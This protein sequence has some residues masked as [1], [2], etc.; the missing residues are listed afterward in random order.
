MKT[1]QETISLLAHQAFGSYM[2][3]S[4]APMQNCDTG[5]VSFIFEIGKYVVDEDLR[6]KYTQ[7]QEEY[8]AKLV[9]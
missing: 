5:L 4:Y 6:I 9:K 2:S 8:D 7:I 1:Y 3:G